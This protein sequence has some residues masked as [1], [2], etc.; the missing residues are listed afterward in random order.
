[1]PAPANSP[2]SAPLRPELAGLL[3]GLRRRI[4]GYVLVRGFALVLASAGAL[5]WLSLAGE[6]A[7]FRVTN[8]EPPVWLRAGFDVVALTL[9]ATGLIGWVLFRLARRLP[10]RALALALERRYP[11]LAE[12]LVLAVERAEVTG[13]DESNFT[14]SLADHAAAAAARDAGRFTPGAVLDTRP[15]R[16][17]VLLAGGAAASVATLAVVAPAA[18][19]NWR[20][21][22]VDLDAAYRARTTRL[23][24]TAV[25]QPGDVERE[26][27]ENRTL[28]HPRGADLLLRIS[29]PGGNRPDGRPWA[30]PEQVTAV[31]RS[32]VGGASRGFTL[33]DGPGRFR[34]ALDDVRDGLEIWFSGG[35]YTD[36]VPYRVVPVD[37]PRPEGVA[38]LA[39]YPEYTGLNRRDAGGEIAPD[40]V[41]VRGTR[42][43]V[44][45]GTRFDLRLTANKPLADATVRLGDVLVSDATTGGLRWSDDRRTLTLPLTMGADEA[46]PPADSDGRRTIPPR[47]LAKIELED[48]DGIRSQTPIRLL[49]AGEPDAPP[50]VEAEPAGVS[51]AVTR[52]AS[53]P[54]TGTVTDDYGVASARFE[55]RVTPADAEAADAPP[56]PKPPTPKPS[57]RSPA[58]T[59]NHAPSTSHP[60]TAPNASPSAGRTTRQTGSG[61]TSP[62]W[63]CGPGTR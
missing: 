2:S 37:P 15:L 58:T 3:S 24:V 56:T 5:F 14:R 36:R 19:H 17:A 55:F 11:D 12:R 47:T 51:D 52:T 6:W 42:A 18:V 45:V 1:M 35:D 61:S 59:G 43:A 23:V 29:V 16:R 20:E 54:V 38:L 28:K 32:A 39:R 25:T 48:R 60:A 49:L 62:R 4:R 53:V 33:P 63:T 27:G 57:T 9:L 7:W 34:F 40:T 41:P 8:F 50:R 30:V 13:G 22:F 31:R 26:I 10:P 21:A 44:P 46:A